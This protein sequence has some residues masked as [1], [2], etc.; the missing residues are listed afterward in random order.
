MFIIDTNNML[1]KEHNMRWNTTNP[2]KLFTLSAAKNLT[3]D[4]PG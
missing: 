2:N 1:R 4:D 3:A